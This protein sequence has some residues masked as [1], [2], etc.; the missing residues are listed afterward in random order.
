LNI[1][2]ITPDFNYACGRSYYV[3]LLM[4]YLSKSGHNV[5][6]LTNGG[7]SFERLSEL[8]LNFVIFKPLHL[9]DPIS[10]ARSLMKVKRI[11]KRHNIDI[12]HTHHRYSELLAIIARKGTKRKNIKTV[13][14][15]LSF[16]DK[17]Y[18]VEYR[19][20]IIIAVSESIRK[21]LI[22][23]FSVDQKRIH[24]ISNFVDSDEKSDVRVSGVSHSTVNIN[25]L[26]VGRFHPDKNYETLFAAL[27]F[28]NNKSLKTYLIGEGA[29]FEKYSEIVKKNS[30]NVDFVTPRKNLH[31]HFLLADICILTSTKEPF[32]NFM[33]QSGL[34]NKPFIGTNVDGIPELI[35]HK[36]NGLLF[37][38]GNHI[39]LAENIETFRNNKTLATNCA[40]ELNSD[41]IAHY[42]QKSILPKIEKLYQ[43]L[44]TRIQ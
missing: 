26:S 20:D 2:H 13:F 36:K 17:K 31:E 4:K 35:R 19:S 44:C 6:L 34:Q 25:I 16:V 29:D 28:L 33:L 38:P 23:K 3:F 39:Q 15:S 10:Y 11:I 7:D 30:L 32:P 27:H 21:M 22:E 12:I 9:K 42:T 18:E 43:E 5:I 8:N 1:L 37:E 40:A 14:T 24:L 41:V